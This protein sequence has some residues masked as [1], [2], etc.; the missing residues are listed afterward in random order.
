MIYALLALSFGPKGA[1]AHR[2]LQAEQARQE[3][4][5]ESLQLINRELENAVSSLLHDTD[6]LAVFARELGYAASHERFIRVVGLGGYQQTRTV[7]GDIVFAAVPQY[8]P[9]T[10]LMAIAF[11]IG[12]AALVCMVVFDF[13]KIL[14]E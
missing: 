1:S 10:I 14:R 12:A 4:N 11:F 9:N 2:Q 3:A 6:T 8:I 13:M 7:P 5:I